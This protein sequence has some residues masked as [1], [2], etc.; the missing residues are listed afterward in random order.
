MR[1]LLSVIAIVLG[2]AGGWA[3]AGA[4][5]ARWEI[6]PGDDSRV[7]FVSKAPIETFTGRTKQVSGSCTFDAEELDGE[8]QLEVAVEMASFDT[9]LAMRNRHMRENHLETDSFPKSWLRGGTVKATPA[10]SL[11]VGGTVS[12]EFVGELELHGVRRPVAC[13]I[14]LERPEADRVTARAEFTV[15]LADYEIP[16]PKMLM[17]KLADEQLVRVALTLRRMS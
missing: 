6:V 16:R 12:V 3:S 5:T 4:A 10:S 8:V 17:L 15:K 2:V 14:V 11:P 9:G 1:R 13:T 7:E